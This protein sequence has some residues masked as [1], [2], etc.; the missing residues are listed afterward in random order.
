LKS[1]STNE[2][3]TE[4][5]LRLGERRQTQQG[6]GGRHG[7]N[8]ENVTATVPPG[9]ERIKCLKYEV[10]QRKTLKPEGPGRSGFLFTF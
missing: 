7:T 9:T 5:T 1:T 8:F 2:I 4:F 10:M 6:I 3:Y